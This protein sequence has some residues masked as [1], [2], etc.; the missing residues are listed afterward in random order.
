MPQHSAELPIACVESLSRKF[1]QRVHGVAGC[2][3]ATRP[4]QVFLG[5]LGLDILHDAVIAPIACAAGIVLTRL[6]PRG[7]VAPVRAGL[8]ASAAV[9]IVG[10]AALRGY[11]RAKVPDNPT[12][13]PLHYGEAVLVVL[14]LV[15]SA[16]AL[17]AAVAWFRSRRMSEAASP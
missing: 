3:T 4:A 14:A 2:V 12:V 7:W 1:V 10:W 13:D 5:S 6:L 16:A 9:M 17:W 15:W 8:F 11:G